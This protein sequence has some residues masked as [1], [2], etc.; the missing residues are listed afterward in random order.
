MVFDFGLYFAFLSDVI[1]ILLYGFLH[2]EYFSLF[3]L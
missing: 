2:G 3:S 1:V